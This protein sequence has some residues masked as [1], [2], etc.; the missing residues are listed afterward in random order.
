LFFAL[1]FLRY[2]NF[3]VI[4]KMPS[5]SLSKFVMK[6]ELP[7]EVKSAADMA[8]KG[9]KG[10]AKGAVIA[11][12]GTVALAAA[13]IIAPIIA[14]NEIQRNLKLRADRKKKGKRL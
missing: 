5:S 6:G 9:A 7:S 14:K 10:V 13:P 3:L 4:Y 1:L 11:T 12:R 8:A 2:Y